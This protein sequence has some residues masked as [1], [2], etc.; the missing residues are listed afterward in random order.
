MR[1]LLLNQT[2]Y[3]DVMATGQYVAA[4]ARHLAQSG[5]EVTV[6]ASR[7]GYDAPDKKFLKKET[8]QGVKIFR[9]WNTGFGK[10]A[11][12][13]R[14]LNFATYLVS[15]CWRLFWLGR[16]DVVVALTS[17]PLV[18][19]IGAAYSRLCGARFCY[20]IMDLNPDEAIAA[21]WLA[22]QSFAAKW[23][24]RFSRFSLRQASAVIV[25]DRFMQRRI[26][27]KNISPGNVSV[28]APWSHD[29]AVRFDPDGRSGFR[30]EHGF[31]KK[32]LVMYSGNHSPCH[33]LDTLLEAAKL[34]AL[35]EDIAF[36]FAGGGSEF[37]KVK[38]FSHDNNLSNVTC[39]PYQPLDR[40][41]CALSA[42]DLHVVV[43]G[44]PF[45][46][47]VHPCKLYNILRVG[48]PVLYIGP[49]PS[50]VSDILER[51]PE[52][53][54]AQ[55]NHGQA[56]ELAQKIIEL[57]SKSLAFDRH[58]EFPSAREFSESTLLPRLA[59]LL[60]GSAPPEFSEPIVR[61][62]AKKAELLKS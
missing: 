57:K 42:A 3:P 51:C 27:D 59:T 5:H 15:C 2:F 1:I 22:P 7:R 34:L 43:M 29:E 56:D 47:L 4:L 25:L 9:E 28:I 55:V 24:E 8:W 6:I 26:L 48:S 49:A 20:W 60:S 62:D 40:L 14:G 37:E 31:G 11:K 46:G 19:V 18:S 12:W 16:Q 58:S 35:H 10:G 38:K 61:E 33:P 17:P 44:N 36:C 32:F 41:A 52:W 23:L 21:G 39:L 45:V 54:C 13:K 30:K 50:H 53:P